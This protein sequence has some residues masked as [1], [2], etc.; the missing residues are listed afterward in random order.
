MTV[1]LTLSYANVACFKESTNISS[2]PFNLTF[3]L[4]SLPSL[5]NFPDVAL[6]YVPAD[7]VNDP[8]IKGSAWRE[9][10]SAPPFPQNTL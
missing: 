3:S 1:V 9:G 2:V 8:G 10:E 7:D 4:F 6:L 5:F